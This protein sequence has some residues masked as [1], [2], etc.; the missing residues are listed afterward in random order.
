VLVAH[1]VFQRVEAM[2]A[3]LEAKSGEAE[4]LGRLPDSIADGLRRAGVIRMLQ[5]REYG[6][7]EADPVSF[8][9]TVM[10]CSRHCGAAGWVAGVVGVHPWEMALCDPKVQGEV[11]GEDPDTWIASPYAPIG[12]GRR[13]DGGFIFNGRFPFSS[14]TDHCTWVFLG[15]MVVDDDGE[16]LDPPEV[17]HFILPREDY[18]IDHDSWNV[19][20]LRGTGSKDVVVHDA[21]VPE[22]RT[23][24]AAKVLDGRAWREAER[25]EPLYRTP[26]SAVF[27]PAITASIIGIA[28]GALAAHINHQRE[29]MGL[30]VGR[31]AEDPY[32][33]AAIGEAASE[34]HAS[35]TQMISNTARMFDLVERGQEVPFELRAQGRRDQVRSCWRAVEA[36]DKVFSHSGGASL[37][38]SLPLQ[39]FWRDA[40]AGLNHAV[41]VCGGVYATYAS[42]AMGR[43]VDNPF[44]MTI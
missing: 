9:E 11:W 24:E 1:E 20:G 2:A 18:A 27:P 13:V 31:V 36:I 22:Y 43:D 25:E 35:R 39:R 6:G 42:V 3:E 8:L 37:Q 41:H 12:R 28:E 44:K 19:V 32:S 34:I 16:L 40:H 14:G 17:R 29:R 7:Y 38:T 33:M 21:F 5:P 4:S 23:I 10:E 26:W 15:G 30:M